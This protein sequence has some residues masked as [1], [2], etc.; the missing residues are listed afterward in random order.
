MIIQAYH[1]LFNLLQCIYIHSNKMILKIKKNDCLYN[2]LYSN[3]QYKQN[4]LKQAKL[5][6]CFIQV[7]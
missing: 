2:F 5:F 7:S 4:E 3:M 6:D 1:L